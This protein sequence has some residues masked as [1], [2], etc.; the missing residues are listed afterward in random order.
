MLRLELDS[1]RRTVE[2]LQG[3]F[4]SISHIPITF[5]HKQYQGKPSKAIEPRR[6]AARGVRAGM[7]MERLVRQYVRTSCVQ[8]ASVSVS[9]VYCSGQI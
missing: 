6:G 4:I 1:R 2:N 8:C 9:V 3:G 5:L 7:H